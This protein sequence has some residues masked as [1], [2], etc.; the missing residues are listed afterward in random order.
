M[1][2]LYTDLYCPKAFHRPD[3]SKR[4]AEYHRKQLL[5]LNPPSPGL[6]PRTFLGFV[7]LAPPI[8]PPKQTILFWFRSSIVLSY[9]A[10]E[11]IFTGNRTQDILSRTWS[12]SCNLLVETNDFGLGAALLP[13][14]VSDWIQLHW[15]SNS[16]HFHSTTFLKYL[17]GFEAQACQVWGKLVYSFLSYNITYIH[18]QPQCI[19]IM[20]LALYGIMCR[21]RDDRHRDAGRR[22]ASVVSYGGS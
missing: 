19:P 13:C 12:L 22:V 18:T 17:L 8:S 16:G 15:D 5:C 1:F 14:L 6:E 3:H 4:I 10:T 2:A 9:R 21:L 20:S 11:N 7:T